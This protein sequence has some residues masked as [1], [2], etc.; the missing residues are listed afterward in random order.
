M[1]LL[2]QNQEPQL[3]LVA[4]ISNWTGHVPTLVIEYQ[5]EYQEMLSGLK[6]RI[7]FFGKIALDTLEQKTTPFMQTFFAITYEYIQEDHFK[8]DVSFP[9]SFTFPTDPEKKNE[10]KA[11]YLKLHSLITDKLMERE[12]E[13][14]QKH[15]M[16]ILFENSLPKDTSLTLI[17]GS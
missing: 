17:G 1:L 5:P 12:G 14:K 8:V 7:E 15:P 9:N 3:L 10:F 2:K 11:S 13:E 4:K 16:E 6:E